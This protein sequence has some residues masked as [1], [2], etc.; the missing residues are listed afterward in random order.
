M[1]EPKSFN[2]LMQEYIQQ[3][4]RKPSSRP[5]KQKISLI[6]MES[7][8]QRLKNLTLQNQNQY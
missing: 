4:N 2:D 7:L 8:N 6:Q 3:K 1:T 5:A